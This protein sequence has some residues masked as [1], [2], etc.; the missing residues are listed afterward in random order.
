MR[1]NCFRS[2]LVYRPDHGSVSRVDLEDLYAGAKTTGLDAG[3]RLVNGERRE[4]SSGTAVGRFQF[5]FLVLKIEFFD[6]Y[7]PTSQLRPFGN[8]RSGIAEDDSGSCP[9]FQ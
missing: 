9:P 5:R 8:P 6:E 7:G 1:W 3:G 2:G 4:H